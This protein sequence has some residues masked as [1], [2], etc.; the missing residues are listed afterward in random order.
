MAEKSCWHQRLNALACLS[1]AQSESKKTKARQFRACS[2]SSCQFC[3]LPTIKWSQFQSAACLCHC[4]KSLVS[5]LW[6]NLWARQ[7]LPSC[8]LSVTHWRYSSCHWGHYNL[9]SVLSSEPLH[10]WSL[11]DGELLLSAKQVAAATEAKGDAGQGCVSQQ[12]QPTCVGWREGFIPRSS[13]IFTQH[14]L[15]PALT[16]VSRHCPTPNH[17]N[18]NAYAGSAQGPVSTPRETCGRHLV[19]R[20]APTEISTSAGKKGQWL[21][22]PFLPFPILFLLG[23]SEFCSFPIYN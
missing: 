13:D 21:S 14:Y 18:S 15:W 16:G 10:E 3:H 23:S 12:G 1:S 19:A 17:T 22:F 7:P 11:H 4:P 20:A 2:K 6:K 9:H 8:N 5:L